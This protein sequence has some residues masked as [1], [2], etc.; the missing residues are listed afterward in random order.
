M[1]SIGFDTVII[2]RTLTVR[3]LIIVMSIL[4]VA[5]IV[6]WILDNRK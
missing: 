6:G 4:T 3:D 1:S 2:T 5:G